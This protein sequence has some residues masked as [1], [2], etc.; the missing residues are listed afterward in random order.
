MLYQSETNPRPLDG[1]EKQLLSLVI[2]LLL[3]LTALLGGFVWSLS[4]DHMQ[5][6]EVMAA[7]ISTLQTK[8]DKHIHAH[9]GVADPGKLSVP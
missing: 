6:I 3:G 9:S 8:L 1:T 5:H 7:D 4:T 2:V